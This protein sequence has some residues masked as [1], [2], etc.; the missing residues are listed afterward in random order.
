MTAYRNRPE[1][2][3]ATF[4]DWILPGCADMPGP[5]R[6]EIR[7]IIR[8]RQSRYKAFLADTLQPF[9]RDFPQSKL[10]ECKSYVEVQFKRKVRDWEAL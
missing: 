8:S 5:F 9:I 1:R 2:H 7:L 6:I 10:D 4:E 3:L